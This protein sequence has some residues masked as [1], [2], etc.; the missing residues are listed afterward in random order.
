[1]KNQTTKTR[2]NVS[3][4]ISISLLLLII[5]LANHILGVQ[6]TAPDLNLTTSFLQ[7][8]SE[9]LTTQTPGFSATNTTNHPVESTKKPIEIDK[10]TIDEFCQLVR[11]PKATCTCNKNSTEQLP[12][13][14]VYCDIKRKTDKSSN[15]RRYV[16]NSNYKTRG[17]TMTTISLFGFFGNSLVIAVTK[18]RWRTSTV[19][20]KLIGALALSDLIF[21][22]LTFTSEVNHIWS[23]KWVLGQFMCKLVLPSINMTATMAL[24]FILIISVERFFGV[25]YPFNQY[26]TKTRI[27]IMIVAN[28]LFSLVV[29]IPGFVVVNVIDDFSC[30]ESWGNPSHSL[31]YSWIFLFVTFLIPIGVI[32]AFYTKILLSIRASQQQTQSTF[33][34]KQKMQRKQEDMRITVILACLLITFFILVLPNRI[35]WILQDHKMLVNLTPYETRLVVNISNSAYLLHAAI[36]PIIYSI[37][38]KRFR[39]ILRNLFCR[40]CRRHQ[41]SSVNNNNSNCRNA[42]DNLSMVTDT[43]KM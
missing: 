22:L 3:Q 34:A 13:L 41:Q 38:D 30:E 28:V 39:T 2:C 27:K 16:C 12:F 5:P 11:I 1:M 18:Q 17:I 6:A 24:G 14:E 33:N 43:S 10:L 23:C 25:V 31:I 21:S 4:N 8:T 15:S 37:V 20:Q 9:I 29:V 42:H 19:S 36:N 40:T 35:Y 32:F 7:H 26:V